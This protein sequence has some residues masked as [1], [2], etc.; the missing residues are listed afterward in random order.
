[1]LEN[2]Q[3]C[4]VSDEEI[5]KKILDVTEIDA[6][7]DPKE[8]RL[9]I[10]HSRFRRWKSGD[11]HRK[12][13]LRCGEFDPIAEFGKHP[14]TKDKLQGWCKVCQKEIG[15]TNKRTIQ[16]RKIAAGEVIYDGG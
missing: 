5:L 15:G 12:Y 11:W 2:K 8:L 7:D 4:R 9:T 14:W 13:C 16:L 10:A 6:M 1:M 3:Q